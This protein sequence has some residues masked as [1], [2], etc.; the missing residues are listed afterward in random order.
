MLAA[1]ALYSYKVWAYKMRVV[2]Q[3]AIFAIFCEVGHVHSHSVLVANIAG[4]GDLQRLIKK[5]SITFL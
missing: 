3:I 4:V 2:I 1:I 5:S